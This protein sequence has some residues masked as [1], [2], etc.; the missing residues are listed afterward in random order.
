[1]VNF[2]EA[3]NFPLIF[4]LVVAL[5]GVAT[6]LHVLVVSVARRRREVGILKS[7]GFVG[8]QV[9]YSV[10][11]QATTVA[12]VG[13]VLDVPLGIAVG[14]VVWIAFAENVGL[15]PFL[16]VNGLVLAAIAC[17]FVVFA[18]LLAIGPAPAW[19]RSLS[20]SRLQPE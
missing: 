7:L 14:H 5:F 8:R 9:A 3:V 18:N 15:F 1:M 11:G 17:G 10:S 20:A 2:G 6:L 4:G 16:A 12:L 13:I 19:A